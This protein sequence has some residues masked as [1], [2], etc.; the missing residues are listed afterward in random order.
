MP[1]EGSEDE[2]RSGLRYGKWNPSTSAPYFKVFNAEGQAIFPVTGRAA[3]KDSPGSF[4]S[5]NSPMP[6]DPQ[7][8][9][10][11]LVD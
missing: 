2:P 6:K 1:P 7:R 10:A 3:D 11:N 4:D 8:Y 5:Y 9:P